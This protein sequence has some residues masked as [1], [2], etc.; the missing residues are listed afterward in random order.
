[1]PGHGE[2]L[3]HLA[4]IAARRRDGVALDSLVSRLAADSLASGRLM[5]LR[6]LQAITRRD[7][8]EWARLSDSASK[9][10]QSAVMALLF[11]TVAHGSDLRPA[12]DLARLLTN[13]GMDPFYR[14][15][16]HGMAAQIEH[17]RG[18]WASA[19]R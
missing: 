1:E 15:I 14:G 8:A 3:I 5:E 2:A 18:R 17:A 10:R 12:L 13:P 6:A 19:R 7:T 9:L 4:R 11:A 16:G